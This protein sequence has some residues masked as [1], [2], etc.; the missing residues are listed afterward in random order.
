MV[1]THFLWPYVDCNE[2]LSSSEIEEKKEKLILVYRNSQSDYMYQNTQYMH[3]HMEQKRGSCKQDDKIVL[4]V[5]NKGNKFISTYLSTGNNS[6][7]KRK[8]I[9]L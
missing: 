2:G 9:I 8:Y 5:F 7:L 6:K 3:M 4:K 1:A